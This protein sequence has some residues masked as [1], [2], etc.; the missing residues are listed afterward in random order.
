MREDVYKA[1]MKDINM[2]H[3]KA[4][5]N[6]DRDFAVSNSIVKIGDVVTD[7]I[8]SVKVESIKLYRCFGE[9][10]RLSYY[11]IRLKKNGL[12]FVSGEKRSAY[13]MNLINPERGRG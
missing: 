13:Q 10:P 8:G 9:L 12:P 3:E 2:R 6:L 1:N 11:G 5:L 4:L 7:H